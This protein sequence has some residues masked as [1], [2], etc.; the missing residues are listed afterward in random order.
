MKWKKNTSLETTCGLLYIWGPVS[1]D[2]NPSPFYLTNRVKWICEPRDTYESE[3]GKEKK[4]EKRERAKYIWT[5]K[6][7]LHHSE[8]QWK[9]PLS[10]FLWALY[11]HLSLTNKQANELICSPRRTFSSSFSI[12]RRVFFSC[13]QKIFLHEMLLTERGGRRTNGDEWYETVWEYETEG[14][15]VSRDEEEMLSRST[16]ALSLFLR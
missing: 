7:F 6:G 12:T 15:T 8:H 13:A 4:K 3:R 5:S 1:A 16:S 9:N 11:P 10:L 14:G 2:P